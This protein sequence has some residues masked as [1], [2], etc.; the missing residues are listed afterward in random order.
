M[1]E[2]LICFIDGAFHCV[3]NI[4]VSGTATEMAGNQLPDFVAGILF[5]AADDFNR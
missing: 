2:E 3:Y 1:L 5:S 4:L